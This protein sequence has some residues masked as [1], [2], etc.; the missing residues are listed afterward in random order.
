[1]KKTRKKTIYGILFASM[2]LVILLMMAGCGGSSG[3]V[4][5]WGGLG[6][7]EFSSDGSGTFRTW[8]VSDESFTWESD[9]STLIIRWERG[10]VDTGSYEIVGGDSLI[11]R[12]LGYPLS[13]TWQR[14][15]D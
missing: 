3:P 6:I 8:G 2:L 5:R 10:R 14:M 7:V 15:E 12:G 9:S 1:M 13:G 11:L 4:G